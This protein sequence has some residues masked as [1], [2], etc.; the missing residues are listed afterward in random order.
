MKRQALGKGL[1]S[2]IPEHPLA[3][4]EAGLLMLDIDRI[5]PGRHQPRADFSD[6]EGLASSIKENGMVQ[7]VIVRQEGGAYRLIAG[8]RRWRAAQLAG[9]TRIPAVVRRIADDRLL[10]VALIENI[11]RKELNPI[12]EAQAYEILLSE[13]KLSQGDIAR[14]VGRDRSSI[15]NYLR[16]L[17]LPSSIRDR[18]RDGTISMGHA[19]AIM[20]LSDS[21]TQISVAEEIVRRLLSV[22]ETEDRVAEI[23]KRPDKAAGRK[24]SAARGDPNIGAAEDRLC[25][26]LATKVRIHKK[27]V[28]GRIEI[29]FYSD[30][31]LDRLFGFL[32]TAEKGH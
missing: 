1:S 17:K 24:T 25:R 14:R 31:E 9:L 27:G 19:K 20:A 3:D 26:A 6:L 10:E 30:D 7:P 15:S 12:E 13:M 16:I 11:Q 8:E 22:R 5:Q 23:A 29:Q 21:G 2:L 18:I 4:R 32:V 28:R